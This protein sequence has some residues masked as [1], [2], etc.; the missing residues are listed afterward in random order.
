MTRNAMDVERFYTDFD[1]R[2]PD[3][4]LRLFATIADHVEARRVLYPGSYVDIAPSVY[5]DDVTYIDIDR[6]AARF[7]ALTDNVA[8][9]IQV[10]RRA[11]ADHAARPASITFHHLDYTGDLPLA[12]RSFD[13]LISLYAGFISEHCTRYLKP[14][15]H[16]LVNPSHG[17]ASLAGIDSRYRLV[18]VISH[19]DGCYT[20]RADQL[21]QYLIPKRGT[22]PTRSELFELGRGIAYTRTPYAYLFRRIEP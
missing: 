14:G 15:G 4:R 2:H 19:R 18:A 5:Y 22:P 10:K 20:I 1:S 8:A 11:N 21:G 13:L 12:E 3:D 7:F 16:L 17:D 6:R 9:L